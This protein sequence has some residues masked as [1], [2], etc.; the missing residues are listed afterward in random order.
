MMMKRLM[1][2]VVVVALA[3]FLAAPAFAT[4]VNTEFLL[5]NDG[6]GWTV[7]N[8]GSGPGIDYLN[9]GYDGWSLQFSIGGTQ[10]QAEPPYVDM[11]LNA[12]RNGAANLDVAFIDTNIGPYSDNLT[13]N[14]GLTSTGGGTYSFNV[15]E[16]PSVAYTGTVPTAAFT[17]SFGTLLAG[18]PQTTDTIASLGPTTDMTGIVLEQDFTGAS[19]ISDDWSVEA[20]EPS[21]FLL[22]GIGLLGAAFFM[23]KVKKASA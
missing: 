1:M 9:S 19:D 7:V 18:S 14:P 12:F 20:P 2:F 4:P 10:I 6:S 3:L 8:A 23:R 5:V 17:G 16:N 15:Y 22:L 13:S 21:T 11:S